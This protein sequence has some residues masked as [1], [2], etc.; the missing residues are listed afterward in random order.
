MDDFENLINALM[1]PDNPTRDRAEEAFNMFVKTVPENTM[2]SLVNVARR[3]SNPWVRS[4]GFILIRRTMVKRDNTLTTPDGRHPTFWEKLGVQAQQ[5]VKHELLAALSDEGERQVRKKLGDTVSDVSLF[6]AKQMRG[7]EAEWPELLPFLFNLTKSP[8]EPQRISALDIFGSLCQYIGSTLKPHYGPLKAVLLS[9]LSDSSISVRS[10]A[11]SAGL[12]LVQLL[13]ESEYSAFYDILPPM[14]LVLQAALE[15]GLESA[16]TSALQVFVDCAEE[17]PDFMRPHLNAILDAMLSLCRHPMDSIKQLAL[18]FLITLAEARP[19]MARAID[20]FTT[21][22]VPVIMEFIMEVEEYPEWNETL[23]EEDDLDVTNNL[24]GEECM[25]RLALAIRGKTICPVV[26]NLVPTLLGNADWRQRYTG[27]VSICLVGEGSKKYIAP[28]LKDVLGLIMPHFADP[29]YRVRWAACNAIGQMSTDFGPSLQSEFHADIIP[30]LVRIMESDG[31]NPRV[32][33]H[34]ASAVV[35]FSEMCAVEVMTTYLDTLLGCMNRL[36]A[37]SPSRIL[38]EQAITAVAAV[39]DCVRTN[40]TPYYEHFVPLIKRVI[41][42]ALGEDLRRLRGKTFE[43]F[44]FIA[45][46][47]GK[48]VSRGDCAEIMPFLVQTIEAIAAD[49]TDPQHQ[50]VQKACVR[51][52]RVLGQEFQ[53]F[54][55]SVIPRLIEA[56]KINTKVH[57]LAMD[58]ATQEG[59]TYVPLGDQKLAIHTTALEEKADATLFLYQYSSYLK[60]AFMPFVEEVASI[61]IP[62]TGYDLHDGVRRGAMTCMTALINCIRLYVEKSGGGDTTPMVEIFKAMLPPWLEA[63]EEEQD[64][65]CTL[66][67]LQCLSDCLDA[68]GC[69]VLAPDQMR[70]IFDR[71]KKELIASETRRREREEQAR[72]AAEFDED[73]ADRLM[74]ENKDENSMLVE[75]A[76]VLGKT[77]KWHK[78]SMLPL[79][80]EML[81]KDVMIMLRRAEPHY[82]QVAICIFDDIAEHTGPEAVPLYNDFLPVMLEGCRDAD[83][84]VRQACVYGFGACAQAGGAAFA[85]ALPS[86]LEALHGIITHS[87][88]RS[89]DHIYVTENAISSFGKILMHQPS[90]NREELLP[91]WLSWLPVTKDHDESPVT[92]GTLCDLIQSHGSTV[93]GGD[94]SRLPHVLFIFA[95]VLDTE[96][97]SDAV[98]A[99]MWAILKA[100]PENFPAEVLQQAVVKLPENLRGKLS[101]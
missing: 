35:N 84:S 82:K 30:N 70:A 61:M 65:D 45:N 33:A 5:A 85:P 22:L 4:M 44:S 36:I 57:M 66:L 18:E 12:C 60:E 41:R 71:L 92:Y 73:E 32:Q 34:A 21:M 75:I 59:W 55:P 20:S 31:A 96:L 88:A 74:E 81:L 42:E 25:D 50:Y 38:Q 11:L 3:S 17:A 16:S 37:E 68:A 13:D 53:P 91:V 7:L 101:A 14:L 93:F 2:G 15:A 58:A 46:A 27:L 94:L 48:E 67:S 6:L 89:D 100:M 76:E 29:H 54:M 8:H 69:P 90:V 97:L 49:P 83:S 43:A 86:V 80:S 99:R 19:A 24:V 95:T 1:S 87:E 28:N 9:S 77:V 98:S 72:G 78:S 79:F 47:V 23:Q 10:S 39:A 40:F 56:A 52:C 64:I 51:I 26:F 62:L 63:L